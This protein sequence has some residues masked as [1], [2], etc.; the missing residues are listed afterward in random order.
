M[1]MLIHTLAAALAIWRSGPQVTRGCLAIDRDM[2]GFVLRVRGN[3]G[4]SPTWHGLDFSRQDT[5]TVRPVTDDSLC[6]LAL[7]T[8][9]AYLLPG[10][11]P[12]RIRLVYAGKYFVAEWA[13]DHPVPGSEFRSQYFLDSTLKQV[14]FPCAD[15]T[16]SC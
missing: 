10:N 16:A 12:E 6:R 1:L 11:A 5:S 2:G 4:R 14:L 15:A 7:K 3:V 9:H 13:P 8:I